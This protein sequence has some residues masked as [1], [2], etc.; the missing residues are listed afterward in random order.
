MALADV[1]SPAR[2]PEWL[3]GLAPLRGFGALL[4]VG[5]HVW[6]ESGYAPL[7][8]GRGRD[9]IAGGYSGV[10]LFFVLSGCVLFLP[11]ARAGGS[12]GRWRD[13]WA[14]RL[15]RIYPLYALVLVIAL[16]AHGSL[17]RN[18]TALPPS[19]AGW[20]LLGLHLGFLEQPWIGT[21]Y[22]RLG[23]GVVSVVWTLSVEASFYLLLPFVA[24]AFFRHPWVWTAAVVAFSRV[25]D[26]YGSH[27]SDWAPGLPAHRGPAGLSY[28]Q[29]HITMNFPG[30]AGHFALGMLI[31][32][33]LVRF[34]DS[35][36]MPGLGRCAPL[37]VVAGAAAYGWFLQ[38][39]GHR[40]VFGLDRDW[41]HQTVTWR[42]L[43]GIVLLVVGAALATGRFQ[44]VL[45]S[46]PAHW[47]GE[48]SYGF[49]LLHYPAMVG[50]LIALGTPLGRNHAAVILVGVAAASLVLADVVHRLVEV[51]ARTWL[52]RRLSS[53][54]PR[55][56]LDDAV[57]DPATAIRL[58][59]APGAADRPGGHPSPRSPSPQVEPTGTSRSTTAT[60]RRS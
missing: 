43:P 7:D 14:R 47:S 19:A 38:W 37:V 22:T 3:P 46:R 36:V 35:A 11:V 39:D 50:V 51:P 60:G 49:Y 17:T 30:Y 24:R 20:R 9:F 56:S 34:A 57:R 29:T 5:Y 33:A 58:R 18:A 12:I 6:S 45:A 54:P 44:R 25:W 26:W 52:R 16:L 28:A 55:R 8:N 31:A 2:S 41:T 10:D 21:D 42:A 4:V 32:Y 1:R 53:R 27:L 13:F 59:E 15:A 48:V 40:T 23:L